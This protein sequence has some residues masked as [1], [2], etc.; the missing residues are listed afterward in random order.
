MSL[1]VA[2]QGEPGAFGELTIQTRWGELAT[3]VPARTFEATIEQVISGAC[4]FAVLPV[5]NTTIGDIAP[6]RAALAAKAEAVTV[7]GEVVTPVRH[8]LIALPG[9]TLDS[10]KWVGSH[11]AALGQCARFFAA[12]PQLNQ[13]VAYDTAGAVR[14]LADFPKIAGEKAPWFAA[15]NAQASELAAIASAVAAQRYNLNVLLDG[16][17]D[18]NENATK[19][20]IIRRREQV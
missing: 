14:E 7:E 13:V 15:L 4:D 2:F 1:R 9:A 18:D 11:F 8:A 3:P 5:W 17:Q 6:P 10:V 16:I 19:F 12:R 20:A